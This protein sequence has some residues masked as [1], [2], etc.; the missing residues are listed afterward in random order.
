[1]VGE[2]RASAVP[3]ASI[4]LAIWVADPLLKQK[5][6]EMLSFFVETTKY[7]PPFFNF[8]SNNQRTFLMML[9]W[10]SFVFL[11]FFAICLHIVFTAINVT[12]YKSFLCE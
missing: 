3:L 7:M 6:A 1:M 10:F 2:C 11:I 9:K 12:I 8:L 5:Q 4:L